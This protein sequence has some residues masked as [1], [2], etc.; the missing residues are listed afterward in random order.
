MLHSADEIKSTATYSV[1]EL[2]AYIF[3]TS[4]FLSFSLGGGGGGT[5]KK[6]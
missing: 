5:Y 3:W 1:S 6:T 4:N 2:A